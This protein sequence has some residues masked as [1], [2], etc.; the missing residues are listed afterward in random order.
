MSKWHNRFGESGERLTI[1]SLL[2]R[3][4]F[5]PELFAL[6]D[7]DSEHSLREAV[8]EIFRI[9]GADGEARFV[10]DVT[11]ADDDGPTFSIQEHVSLREL[12]ERLYAAYDGDQK[13]H[14]VLR[15]LGPADDP[16]GE[17]SESATGGDDTEEARP[18]SGPL[19]ALRR[20][21]D[22]V[23]RLFG[24]SAEQGLPPTVLSLLCAPNIAAAPEV[25]K[26][27]PD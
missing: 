15:I 12:A 3:V 20:F 2:P 8:D 22:A 9:G 10:L 17:T 27:N 19:S 23:H 1:L 7:S 13:Y 16:I 11:G 25:P 24:G 26:Q 5:D 18:G 21:R 4:P 14:S 6:F